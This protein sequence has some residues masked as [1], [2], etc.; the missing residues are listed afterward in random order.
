MTFAPFLD[1]IIQMWR[2]PSDL[3]EPSSLGWTIVLGCIA[4]KFAPLN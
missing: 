3:Y 2:S 1:V 4:I